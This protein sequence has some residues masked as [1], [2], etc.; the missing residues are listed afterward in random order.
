[1]EVGTG[2]EDKVLCHPGILHSY[3]NSLHTFALALQELAHSHAGC[4]QKRVVEAALQEL[5]ERPLEEL[6]PEVLEGIQRQEEEH[7][8]Q[9]AAPVLEMDTGQGEVVLH[10]LE[11]EEHHFVPV[12]QLENL[13]PLEVHLVTAV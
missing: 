5:A 11:Q 7:S 10:S 1:M 12:V 8:L 4:L 2:Q 9:Q 13:K 3:H 6:A